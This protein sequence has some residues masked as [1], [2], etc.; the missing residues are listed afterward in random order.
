MRDSSW[1]HW[2]SLLDVTSFKSIIISRCGETVKHN[3]NMVD[4]I[5]I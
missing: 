3:N 5:S 2:T 4:H 1:K